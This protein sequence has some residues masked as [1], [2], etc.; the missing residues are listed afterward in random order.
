MSP[1]RLLLPSLIASCTILFVGCAP[2]HL[3]VSEIAA[4]EDAVLVVDRGGLVR[5]VRIDE[6]GTSAT[7]V[8]LGEGDAS[9]L[10][11]PGSP[12]QALVLTEG[13]LGDAREMAMPS[14]LVLLDRTGELRRWTFLGQYE[15][16]QAS[17]D[18]RYV[19]ALA[20][21]GRLV[22]ENRVEVVDL[23][24][25]AGDANPIALSLRSLGGEA[26]VA[27]EIS[28]VLPWSDGRDLRVAALFAAG[29]LSLFDLDAPD[30]PPVTIPT[31]SDS[32]SVGPAPVEGFFVG[33]EL[34]VRAS[35]RQLLVVALVPGTASRRF[36]VAVR[37]LAASAPIVA[38]A[39]DGRGASPRVLAI[40]AS[41]LDVFDLET[42]MSAVVMV[43][44]GYRNILPFDGPAPGDVTSRP[45]LAL[46]GPTRSI[47]FVELGDR[48]TDVLGSFVLPLS[49]QPDAVVAD[50]DAGRLVVFED[51]RRGGLELDVA[52]SY[53]RRPVSVVDLFDRSAL[54][55]DASDELSRAVVSTGLGDM[56]VAGA[57]GYVNRFDLET[58]EQEERW[59]DHSAETLLP[60]LGPAQRVLALTTVRTGSFA[61]LEAG[62]PP[63]SVTNAW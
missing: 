2:P 12:A 1:E 8:E 34:V 14:E 61:I 25:D 58:E 42:G 11:R 21:R 24:M 3:D 9:L 35:A 23:T 43:E 36:D 38:V 45:R 17:R 6:A 57:D 16:A 50:A 44:A 18:G 52:A 41:T 54:A 7:D 22:V 5:V 53:G 62:M 46:Y 55:L 15:A 63:R 10:A 37:T 32:S 51:L 49:F 48:P 56:W 20:P 33:D 19:V 40:T 59:L 31:T 30:D 47:T 60:L 29:Q 27:A 28:E 39:I 26:P 13:K 4:L